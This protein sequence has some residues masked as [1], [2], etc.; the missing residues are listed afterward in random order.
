MHSV[1]LGEARIICRKVLTGYVMEVLDWSLRAK[2]IRKIGVS[3]PYT[4][5]VYIHES[6]QMQAGVRDRISRTLV[7]E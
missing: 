5:V 2:R 1:R 4:D 6:V 3:L 7:S